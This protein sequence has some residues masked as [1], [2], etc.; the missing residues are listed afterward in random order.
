ME[1]PVVDT[2]RKPSHRPL[3]LALLVTAAMLLG[4]AAA[5]AISIQIDSITTAPGGDYTPNAR[6]GT[7]TSLINNTAISRVVNYADCK[8]IFASD[9][10][11]VRI[12]WSWADATAGALSARYGIKL[13]PP[14]TTCDGNSMTEASSD[15]GCVVLKT[16]RSFANPLTGAGEITDVNL[17]TLLKGVDCSVQQDV[18]ARV[19]FL[20][21]DSSV[22]TTSTPV[23]QTLNIRLDTQPPVAP[24]IDTISGGGENIRLTWTHVDTAATNFARVYWSKVPFSA[25]APSTATNKSDKLTGTSYQITGLDNGTTY[26]VA[27]TAIDSNDNESASLEVREGVPVEVQDFWQYY[28][29]S[30]GSSDAGYYGCTASGVAPTGGAAQGG[31]LVLFALAVL[32]LARFAR[33]RRALATG[34]ALLMAAGAIAAPQTARAES[35][36]TASLDLRFGYYTPQVDSEFATTNGQTPYGTVFGDSSLHKGISLEQI[37][38]D[39]FGDLGIGFSVGWWSMT[40]KAR[41]LDGGS[42]QDSTELL[43][44][45]VSIELVYRFN[46]LAFKTGFPLIPYAKGGIAYAFWWGFDGN[47]D[48]STYTG[49]DNKVTEAQGGVAGLHGTVGLR[50]L[51]DVFEPRAARGFD[52]EMGVNHSYLFCEY[53]VLSL[54]NFGDAKS[55]DLSDNVLMFGLGFDL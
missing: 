33:R 37:L 4:P 41:S 21:T 5:S 22:S 34:L 30:G 44:V 49:A 38:F 7:T 9:S 53:Q 50:L 18:E 39:G 46:W 14:G 48:V 51:L 55:L 1:R 31:W 25:S 10:P 17:A 35:P 28:K 32:G 20:I 2:A 19:Y 15:S 52:L 27:V 16:D 42:A 23:S 54:N 3:A 36:R 29:A 11:S 43:I 8:E 45:P 6:L 12:T 40:G 24:T 26:Y 47:G 13:A